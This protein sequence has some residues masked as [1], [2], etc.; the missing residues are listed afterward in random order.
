MSPAPTSFNANAITTSL[1]PASS[2][3]PAVAD[4]VKAE[5]IITTPAPSPETLARHRPCVT[6]TTPS[7]APVAARVES[8]VLAEPSPSIPSASQPPTCR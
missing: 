4:C 1:A 7:N 6:I 3:T 2:S 5:P 8:S